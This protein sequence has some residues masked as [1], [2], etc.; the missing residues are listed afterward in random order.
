[1]RVQNELKRKKKSIN[2]LPN[3][4][5]VLNTTFDEYFSN[6]HEHF[7]VT[8]QK[9][10]KKTIAESEQCMINVHSHIDKKGGGECGPGV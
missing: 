9:I 4:E 7:K 2:L 10:E 6:S 1:M 8:F 3:C 5:T